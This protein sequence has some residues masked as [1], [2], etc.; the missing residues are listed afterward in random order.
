MKDQDASTP[1]M[2]EALVPTHPPQVP[3]ARSPVP[4]LTTMGI[5]TEDDERG[6][7]WFRRKRKP[8]D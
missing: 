6:W 8:R 2:R 1:P 5:V 3:Y 7:R 4:H